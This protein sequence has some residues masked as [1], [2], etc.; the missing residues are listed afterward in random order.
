MDMRIILSASVS[1]GLVL[2]V[3][4]LPNPNSRLPSPS[5]IASAVPGESSLFAT[6]SDKAPPITDEDL[7]AI[8]ATASGEPDPEDRML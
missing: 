7:K 8:P 6:Y 2:P 4:G 1:F 5:V 3:L